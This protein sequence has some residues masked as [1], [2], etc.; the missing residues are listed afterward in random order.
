VSSSHKPLL[1]KQPGL[2][3]YHWTDKIVV[4]K[5]DPK[6]L[7]PRGAVS[8]ALKIFFAEINCVIYVLSYECFQSYLDSIYVHGNQS[9]HSGLALVYLMLSLWPLSDQYFVEGCQYCTEGMGEGTIES[10]QALM[11]MVSS[12]HEIF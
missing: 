7:P 3:E 11:L 8:E 12:I 1:R 6:N 9:S 4:D 10:V 5:V 2:D